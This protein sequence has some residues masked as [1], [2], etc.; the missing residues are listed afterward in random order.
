MT[1]NVQSESSLFR[2]E[3][4]AL[5]ASYRRFGTLCLSILPSVKHSLLHSTFVILYKLFGFSLCE[6]SAFDTA[7]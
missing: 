2:D 7:L 4:A 3:Y 6:S 5:F 1:L